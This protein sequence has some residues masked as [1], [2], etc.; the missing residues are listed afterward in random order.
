MMNSNIDYCFSQ[1]EVKIYKQNTDERT[2][3]LLLLSYTVRRRHPEQS[4]WERGVD[5]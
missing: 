2:L 4:I 5:V 3:F 1:A